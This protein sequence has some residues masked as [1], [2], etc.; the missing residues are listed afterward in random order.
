[1]ASDDYDS[2]LA[3]PKKKGVKDKGQGKKSKSHDEGKEREGKRTLETAVNILIEKN[4]E[5]NDKVGPI[6]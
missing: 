3:S 1:M 2:D 6:L 4:E 5:K